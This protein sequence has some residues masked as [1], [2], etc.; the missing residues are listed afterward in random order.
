[1]AWVE[2]WRRNRILKSNDRIVFGAVE[3]VH[4]NTKPF[5]FVT[6]DKFVHIYRLET[7]VECTMV[8][9]M[10]SARPLLLRLLVLC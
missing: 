1:M 4:A 6:I 2:M 7:V 10:P 5:V 3:D 8:K 9:S